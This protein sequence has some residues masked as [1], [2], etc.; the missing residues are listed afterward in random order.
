[1]SNDPKCVLQY[2]QYDELEYT[3]CF[4]T[5]LCLTDLFSAYIEGIQL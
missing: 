3:N 2:Q 4:I 1:M 5:I